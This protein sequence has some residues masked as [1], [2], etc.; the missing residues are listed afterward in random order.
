MKLSNYRSALV[1]PLIDEPPFG[2]SV[3]EH[4]DFD[5]IESQ[6]MKVGSLAHEEIEWGKTEEY[7]L[8]L[9]TTVGK[10]IKVLA[11]LVQVLQYQTTPERFNLSIAIWLDFIQNFWETPYPFKGTRGEIAKCRLMNQMI[12]KTFKSFDLMDVKS[13]DV[14]GKEELCHLVKELLLAFEKFEVTNIE[15]KRL[16]EFWTRLEQAK[17]KSQEVNTQ[18]STIV[19]DNEKLGSVP[20]A[21]VVFDSSDERALKRTLNQMSAFLLEMSEKGLAIKLR[22]LALW[23][24][25]NSAPICNSDGETE[26]AAVP[27]DK[28]SMY[29]ENVQRANVDL[30][31]KVENSITLSPFWL[32]GHY[33]SYQ[34]AHQLECYE[35]AEIIKQA[36]QNFLNKLPSLKDMKFK[37]GMPFISSES[38]GWL[39]SASVNQYALHENV[40]VMPSSS[41]SQSS[42]FADDLRDQ[43]LAILR[44]DGLDHAIRYLNDGL[45][46]AQTIREKCYWQ[47]SLAALYQ[48]NGLSALAE[49]LY[50]TV[51]NI[52]KNTK[53]E[54]WESNLATQLMPY[55][56]NN[57]ATLNNK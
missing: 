18:E 45:T 40:K 15:V 48:H 25:I 47:L 3:A 24:T 10:D 27:N 30:W 11:S 55:M 5:F 37:G 38:L 35:E 26:L 17:D 44:D 36:L 50:Q 19:Q 52:V 49:G 54:D 14:Q 53:V 1:T 51:A 13:Y 12:E 2:H 21:K 22:R 39:N 9:L 46:S 23:H 31:D 43:A 42:N 20:Q 4:A 34:I 28:I 8:T 16:Q 33:L 7:C 32:D 57:H 56:K 29:Q 6:L 41:S